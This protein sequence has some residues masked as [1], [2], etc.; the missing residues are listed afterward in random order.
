MKNE[1][2]YEVKFAWLPKVSSN[3]KSFWLKYYIE[4]TMSNNI[5]L[6]NKCEKIDADIQA[7]WIVEHFNSQC[8]NMGERE[9]KRSNQYKKE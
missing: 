8:D 2:V 7:N 1:Y 5:I 3:G 4:V 6:I 9:F